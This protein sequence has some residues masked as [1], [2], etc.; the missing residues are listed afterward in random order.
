MQNASKKK[1]QH[2]PFHSQDKMSS[3]SEIRRVTYCDSIN[4]DLI[5]D[6][7]KIVLL[8]DMLLWFNLAASN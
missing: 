2:P 3:V 5:R 7:L 4:L 1:I 6:N 8:Q